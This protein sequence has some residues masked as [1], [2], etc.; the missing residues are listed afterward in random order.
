M[1]ATVVGVYYSLAVS[2]YCFSM[3]VTFSLRKPKCFHASELKLAEISDTLSD[4]PPLQLAVSAAFAL[5]L[6]LYK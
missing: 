5:Q 6:D 3:S 4:G 1:N 2:A